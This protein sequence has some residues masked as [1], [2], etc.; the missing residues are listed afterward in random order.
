MLNNH[1]QSDRNCLESIKLELEKEIEKNSKYYF[2]R[3]LY[4]T[5]NPL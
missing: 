1:A 2:F 4:A 5:I 3:R